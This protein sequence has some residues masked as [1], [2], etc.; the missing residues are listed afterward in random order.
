MHMQHVKH[1]IEN[2]QCILHDIHNKGVAAAEGGGHTLVM[3]A[4]AEGACVMNDALLVFCCMFDMLH[5]H[6][7]V[8]Y[9][10]HSVYS[11]CII[12]CIHRFHII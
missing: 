7:S 9:S 11:V 4:G 2:K 12:C 3:D 8:S 6:R 5:V 1:T 10:M